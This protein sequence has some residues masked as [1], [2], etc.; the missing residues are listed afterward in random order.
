MPK[1][2]FNHGCTVGA[3]AITGGWLGGDQAHEKALLTRAEV[4]ALTTF[5]KRSRWAD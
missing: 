3:I 1:H 4:F 5:N 2:A